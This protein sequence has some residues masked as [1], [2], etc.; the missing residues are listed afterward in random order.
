MKA[1]DS[2]LLTLLKK[3]SQFIVPIYQRV[4]SWQESEC[5]QLWSDILRAGVTDRMGAHFTGSIVYVARGQSTNTSAEPDLIIDGQQRV[6]T[7]TLV[8]AALA[9]HLDTLPEDEREPWDGLSPKKIRNRY[10]LNDDEDGERQFKLLLSQGDRD[11]LKAIVLGAEPDDDIPTRVTTNFQFFRNKFSDP[12]LDLAALCRGL[13]KLV[14]V[15]V[16]LTRGVD[17]PQLVFEAMNST[18]RKLSQADLIRNYVL[19]DMPPKEQDALYTAYWRP[20]ELEFVG[21]NDSQF[22]EFVRHY[23]TIKTGEI[24]RLGDIYDAFKAYSFKFVTAGQSMDDLVVELRQY[25]KRYG[26]IALGKED[27][28]KLRRAFKDLDQI[29]ADVVYPFLLEVYSDYEAGTITHQ[30]MLDVIEMVTSYVFRRAVCRVPTNSLNKT[31]AGFSSVVRKDRYLDSVKAHFL[32]MK[33][34]RAFPTDADFLSALQTSDLYN[35]RRRSYFLR[36]LENYGRKEHV[37]I[38][39][40]SIE[41]IMPQNENLSEEWQVALGPDWQDVQHRLLHTLGNLTLTGY[42]SE[43]SDHAFAKKRDMEGG[44]RDSPL[45]LNKGLGTLDTWNAGQIEARA[46]RLA[47][48]AVA[49]WSRPSLS[50]DVLAEFQAQGPDAGFSIEDH[51]N[52]LAPARR[53]LFEKFSTEVLALDPGVT[54]HFLKL[55]IAFKAETNFVDIVPQ[56]ARMRLSLNIPIEALHDERGLAWDVSGK[57]HWGN[58]PTEVGLAEDDDFTYV[59]GLVRQ[60]FEYQMGGD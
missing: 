31:F 54:R 8:L 1:V 39:D 23:L 60:A 59:M 42:N 34:Y 2:H 12:A 56:K 25:A 52:L 53:A 21:S 45:R 41:H 50:D 4:Y 5:E 33:S 40:Y 29:K 14:V 19:M 13:D 44:F 7:V 43:Y 47:K 49:I 26:A 10:L 18:G 57:G 37:T 51:P 38:E 16:T 48:E 28:K 30:E 6:T 20:M 35:F 58:G 46:E 15:D 17:N 36:V 27:D 11:A 32:S 55:Y 22:D 24:P 3:S 9:Q